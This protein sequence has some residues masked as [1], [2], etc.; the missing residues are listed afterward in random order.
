MSWEQPSWE[1]PVD[2]LIACLLEEFPA[3]PHDTDA[4]A[5]AVATTCYH[6]LGWVDFGDMPRVEL[7][8]RIAS[9]LA[10]THITA[11][12]IHTISMWLQEPLTETKGVDYEVDFL[13][14]FKEHYE[15]HYRDWCSACRWLFEQEGWE[16]TWYSN[17]EDWITCNPFSLAEE[18]LHN[19]SND[20]LGGLFSND[21][22]GNS[23]FAEFCAVCPKA[24]RHMH[25]LL[26]DY[27]IEQEG[28]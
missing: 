19:F 18:L 16:S 22:T 13:I 4:I 14:W 26:A 6:L 9:A 1:Q 3:W 8:K 15:E 17:F 7:E 25:R 21:D 12:D 11:T 5:K 24:K 2:K 20:N 23:I 28:E 10:W 27:Q